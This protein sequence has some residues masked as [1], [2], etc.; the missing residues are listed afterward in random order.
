MCNIDTWCML[1]AMS[2]KK[3]I[4]FVKNSSEFKCIFLNRSK[5]CYP[6]IIMNT[7]PHGRRSQQTWPRSPMLVASPSV[8]AYYYLTRSRP[9]TDRSN[10][11]RARHNVIILFNR[12]FKRRNGIRLKYITFFTKFPSRLYA[13][14]A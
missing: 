5:M 10:A 12:F 8:F 6:S 3:I 7:K 13:Y 1:T 9:P 14:C 4:Y 11:M 2:Y